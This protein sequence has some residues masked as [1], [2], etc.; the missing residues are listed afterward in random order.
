[1]SLRTPL[2]LGLSHSSSTKKASPVNQ[3]LLNYATHL[4]AESDFAISAYREFLHAI[5]VYGERYPIPEFTLQCMRDAAWQSINDCR[6][7][8]IA[9][10]M[11]VVDPEIRIALALSCQN[12]SASEDATMYALSLFHD[13]CLEIL[14]D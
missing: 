11:N 5:F 9:L 8:Q 14:N 4:Q 7:A 1:M 12:T 10:V 2:S 3:G 6:L 13:R